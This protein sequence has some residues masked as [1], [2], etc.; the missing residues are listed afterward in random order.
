M[1]DT[2]LREVTKNLELEKEIIEILKAL[3]GI[4][5]KIQRI[6]NNL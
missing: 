5:D 1:I 6:K 4:T 2:K 3:R